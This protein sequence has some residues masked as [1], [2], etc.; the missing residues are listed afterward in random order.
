MWIQSSVSTC[1][2]YHIDFQSFSAGQVS[3]ILH[4]KDELKK[5]GFPYDSMF[6]YT[7]QAQY[8]GKLFAWVDRL[9]FYAKHPDFEYK[10]PEAY[11]K[12]AMDWYS[13]T[14]ASKEK[15]LVLLYAD[16]QALAASNKGDEGKAKAYRTVKTE[17]NNRLR[18]DHPESPKGNGS[19]FVDVEIK[20]AHDAFP[21]YEIYIDRKQVYGYLPSKGSPLN[22]FGTN[23][24]DVDVRI[25]RFPIDLHPNSQ[26]S[27]RLR[28]NTK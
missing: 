28:L 9:A 1:E 3:D 6:E 5:L 22:L 16:G 21:A 4:A 17:L 18:P 20:G 2:F 19:L 24:V 14:I 13:L 12:S 23:R 7:P 10:L 11:V 15:D 25:E 8:L 27:S 26:D